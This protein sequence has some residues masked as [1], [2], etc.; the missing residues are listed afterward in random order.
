MTLFVLGAGATRG[1]AFVDPL[2]NPCQPPLDADFFTQ[3]QRVRNS[4]HSALIKKVLQD[5]T[6]LFGFNFQVTLE[7]AFTTYENTIRMLEVTGENRDFRRVELK[8][9]RDRLRQAIAVV[10]EESLTESSG[11]GES[12]LV[13]RSCE[14]H[15]KFVSKILKPADDIISFNYD[16][17]IDYSLKNAGNGVWN[18]RYGYGFYLGSGGMK[19]TGDSHWCPKSPASK[20]QSI[21]LHKLHGSLHFQFASDD[22]ATEVTLKER[23]YTKQYGN[24]RFSIIP[25]EWHKAY[26]RGAYSRLWKNAADALHRA[27]NIVLIG[28][29]LPQTDLHATALFMTSIKKG[30]LK[31]LV[32]VNP[33]PVSRRRT[34]S[35]LQRGFSSDT[36]VL[37]ISTFK[38]FVA[39]DRSVWTL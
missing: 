11:S 3:L 36:R 17:L 7:A 18:P 8:E 9:M 2:K 28:Y 16:C 23:P 39:M 12:K 20:A 6:R 38:E 34:R 14:D 32:V 19:L 5:V 30:A 37:S 35:V 4:K 31:S 1:A 24:L 29:S 15:E 26:D 10:F 13:P 27:R 21:R 22:A 33:D 25:P